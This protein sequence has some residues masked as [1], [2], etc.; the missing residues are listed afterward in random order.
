M[1]VGSGR[2]QKALK[3]PFP[4]AIALLAK[5]Y[6]PPIQVNNNIYTYTAFGR[7]VSLMYALFTKYVYVS[8]YLLHCPQHFSIHRLNLEQLNLER[9]NLERLN[10]EWTEPRM[11]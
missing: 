1:N 9:P 11:D 7:N 10:P 5:S 2:K 3:C 8:H 4:H 6:L